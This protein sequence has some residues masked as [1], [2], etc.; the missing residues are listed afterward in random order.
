MKGATIVKE[1]DIYVLEGKAEYRLI[2]EWVEVEAGDR[3]LLCA[4]RPQGCRAGGPGP[5]RYLLN[6]DVIRIAARPV[7]GPPHLH[8]TNPW[9]MALLQAVSAQP[10][11]SRSGP[12]GWSNAPLGAKRNG[13]TDRGLAI[14]VS[15]HVPVTLHPSRAP[16]R[17]KRP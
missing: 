11:P 6:K 5:F 17:V 10:L 7:S 1:H 9:P 16:L 12:H 14:R 8:H 4:F 15:H 2:Q 3:V 13:R